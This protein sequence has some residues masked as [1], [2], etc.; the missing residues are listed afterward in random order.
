MII[1]RSSGE[2]SAGSNVVTTNPCVVTFVSIVGAAA[3]VTVALHDCDTAA[4][5][6]TANK[7][8]AFKIDVSLNGF[9]GGGNITHPLRF[10]EGLVAVVA[11]AGGLAYV[12]FKKE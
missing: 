10:S 12:G 3:D 6:T 2:L 4:T 1:S 7:L 9:Q 8:V 11:G 5:V